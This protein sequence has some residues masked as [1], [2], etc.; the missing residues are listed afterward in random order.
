MLIE[1]L[2]KRVTNW[3]TIGMD[4]SGRAGTVVDGSGSSIPM[5][6]QA[7]GLRWLPDKEARAGHIVVIAWS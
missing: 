7:R 6:C 5:K 4:T 1:S 3:V 2:K